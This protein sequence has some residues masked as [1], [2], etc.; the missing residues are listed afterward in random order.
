MNKAPRI[1][2]INDFRVTDVTSHR[3]GVSG[4]AFYSVRFSYVDEANGDRFMSN[5]LAV[6]P[7]DAKDGECF[8]LDLNAPTECWRGDN[9]SESVGYAIQVHQDELADGLR[10]PHLTRRQRQ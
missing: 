9:F 3:N 10:L 8:V 2:G 4:R 7:M 6:V 5:M 1:K